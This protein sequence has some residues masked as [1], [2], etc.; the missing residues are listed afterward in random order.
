MSKN[1][2][3]KD[4]IN[5][6]TR[7]EVKNES[8]VIAK[9]VILDTIEDLQQRIDR[10]VEYIKDRCNFAFT[11]KDLIVDILN[12]EEIK[13]LLSILQDKEVE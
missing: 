3:L 8:Q 5:T 11:S 13:E 4:C 12:K 2:F 9:E 1:N 7:L 10:A 6:I